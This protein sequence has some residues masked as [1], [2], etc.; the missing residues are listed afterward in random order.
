MK[1]EHRNEAAASDG[2]SQGSQDRKA[3]LRYGGSLAVML[4]LDRGWGRGLK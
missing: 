3:Y 2:S 4:L 1:V